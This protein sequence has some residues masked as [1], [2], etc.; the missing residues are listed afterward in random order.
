MVN[1]LKAV[2]IK[3]WV[4]SGDKNAFHC[5]MAAYRTGII[6]LKTHKPLPI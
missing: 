4:A 1:L 5:Q 3:T 2:N 6:D